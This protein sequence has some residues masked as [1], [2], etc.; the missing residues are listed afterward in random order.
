MRIFSIITSFTS[1]GAET[2]ATNLSR[3]FSRAGHA[4]VVA[5]L[6][7]AETLGNSAAFEQALRS[8]I[9]E[10]GGEAHSL[11][12]SARRDPLSGM[13]A[14]RRLIRAVQPDVIH[15][16]TARALPMLW[17][18]R[19]AAPV[20]LTHHNTRF[21]FPLPLFHF[22]DRVVGEYVAIS[23]ECARLIRPH[24]SRR[25]TAIRNAVGEDYFT[26]TPR[27]RPGDPVRI[28]SVG[29]LSAQKDYPTLIRAAKLLRARLAQHGR[30]A[31]F[32]IVGGGAMLHDLQSLVDSEGVSDMVE[33]LGT[34]S[35]IRDLLLQADLFVN[36]SLY[37]GLPVAILEAMATGLPVVATRVAGNVDIINDGV[38]GLLAQGGCP[39]ALVAAI[40]RSISDLALYADLS[41]RAIM[42]AR[43]HSIEAYVES[44][45]RVYERLR[46]VV[47][48]EAVSATSPTGLSAY[49]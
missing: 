28:I 34:R 22:F 13:A 25:I 21:S 30:R 35:D 1:G 16:H 4:P 3:G 6:C 43:K 37:E 12:L 11:G 42:T 10:S 45:L 15:T 36:N 27:S 7:D 48:A 23:E 2:L 24:T 46:G 38:N 14:L 17:L 41:R 18:A 33:L 40:D 26:D 32:R 44:H 47:H 39:H 9:T 8:K 19:P 20:V 49:P 31:Q 29:A 5:A